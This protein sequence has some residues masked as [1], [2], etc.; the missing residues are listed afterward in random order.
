MLK[1]VRILCGGAV[2]AAILCVLPALPATAG[3]AEVVTLDGADWYRLPTPF[4]VTANE[5]GARTAH[6]HVAMPRP[7]VFDTVTNSYDGV[8]RI[9]VFDSKAGRD[10]IAR[11]A[12]PATYHVKGPF[13]SSPSEIVFE[14]TT[15]TLREVAIATQENESPLM[16]SLVETGSGDTVTIPLTLQSP[17]LFVST[18]RSGGVRGLG[19]DSCQVRIWAA[20]GIRFAGR[21]VHVSST[22]GDLSTA[23]IHLDASGLG[24]VTLRS[25]GIGGATILAQGYPFAPATADVSFSLP[26][27]FLLSAFSGATIAALLLDHLAG[28]LVPIAFGVAGTTLSA[29]GIK[30][31][32][33]PLTF[34]RGEALA[35]L[36]SFALAYLGILLLGLVFGR[37]ADDDAT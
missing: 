24:Q 13:L 20:D 28:M 9:G 12:T 27:A 21:K 16:A 36:V 11:L 17:R 6:A 10:A 15:R 32:T 31:T 22:K 25:A 14:A 5:N 34:P 23:T 37:T 1:L 8:V 4:V 26:F 18:N 33:F 3:D 2:T 29:I 35:F 19:L 7:L 30:H